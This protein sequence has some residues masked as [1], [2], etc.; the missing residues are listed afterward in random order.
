MLLAIDV[1][2]THTVVGLYNEGE[3][4]QHWRLETQK[5]RTADELGVFLLELFRVTEEPVKVEGIVISNVVPPLQHALGRMGERY[6]DRTPLFIQANLDCGIT[7]QIDNPQEMGADR[8]ANAVAA[9]ALADNRAVIVV[10]FGTA[11]T[12]DGIDMQGNYI[13]GAIAPGILVSHEALSQ[14]ASRLPRIE[15]RKP[16]QVIGTNTLN[17][18]QSGIYYGYVGLVDGIVN[19]MKESIPD[20]RKIIATGGLAGLITQETKTIHEVAPNLTLD[21]LHLIWQRLNKS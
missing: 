7:L 2:N 13:G 4:K 10:D 18:M 3:L 6:F 15:I 14:K 16:D 12:F 9:R 5:A 20:T 11:T 17:S 8:I 1:G 21:G 19:R